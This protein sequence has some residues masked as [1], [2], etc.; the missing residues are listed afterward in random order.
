[1]YD[2]EIMFVDSRSDNGSDALRLISCGVE[3]AVDDDI[4]CSAVLLS[5][6]PSVAGGATGA[7]HWDLC[8]RRLILPYCRPFACSVVV[9]YTSTVSAARE[10]VAVVWW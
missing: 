1:M 2:N 8:V 7:P 4:D 10:H 5:L 9:T 3:I 6:R